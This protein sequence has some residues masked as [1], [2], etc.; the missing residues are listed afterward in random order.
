MDTQLQY[1][2]RGDQHYA[3]FATLIRAHGGEVCR[4]HLSDRWIQTKLSEATFGYVAAIQNAAIGRAL[5]GSGSRYTLKAFILVKLNPAV[6]GAAFI[7]VICA[8]P[9]SQLGSLMLQ[10]AE[11][12]IAERYPH[13]NILT[14]VSLPEPRLVQWYERHGFYNQDTILDHS[15]DEIKAYLMQKDI[16]V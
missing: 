6:P 3:L 16:R 2:E 7:E 12:T 5:R 8:R 14:L 9:G 1:F 15:S 11:S 13:I 10:T 4:N